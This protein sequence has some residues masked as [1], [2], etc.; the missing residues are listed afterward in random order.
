M[1]NLSLE[2]LI[3]VRD[4]LIY[5]QGDSKY[6]VCQITG[7]SFENTHDFQNHHIIPKEF[8][9]SDVWSN[10][11][12]IK[13]DIHKLIHAVEESVIKKYLNNLSLTD[14]QIMVVNYYRKLAHRK[15]IIVFNENKI[16]SMPYIDTA[17]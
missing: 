10:R 3:F 16:I 12:I 11:I 17:A 5:N 6:G 9:G 7:I 8:G 1:R 13:T 15:P 4:N 2:N 14:N